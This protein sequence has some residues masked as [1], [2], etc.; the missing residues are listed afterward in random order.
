MES[1]ELL[2]CLTAQFKYM[3]ISTTLTIQL[4]NY[5]SCFSKPSPYYPTQTMFMIPAY[6]HCIILN[7]PIAASHFVTAMTYI[8]PKR[9][10]TRYVLISAQKSVACTPS[11]KSIDTPFSPRA[12]LHAAPVFIAFFLTNAKQFCQFSLV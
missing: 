10:P 8:H 6:Y 12:S 4:F 3:S 1:S 2:I 7:N 9:C 5:N 11:V